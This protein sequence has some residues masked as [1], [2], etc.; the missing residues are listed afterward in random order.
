MPSEQQQHPALSSAIS[1]LDKLKPDHYEIYFERRTST[2]IDSKNLEIDSL[3][4]SEDVGLAIRLIKNQRMGFSFTTSLEDVAIQKAVETAYEVAKHM[5]ADPFVSLH[6]FDKS[7]YPHVDQFDQQGLD[8]PL[9]QKIEMAKS[10]ESHCRKADKRITG[11]RQASLSENCYEVQMVDSNGEPILYKSTAFV[12]SVSCKA[13]A[14][15]DSQMGGDFAF[16]HE[17]DALPLETVG[18]LA[19]QWATELLGSKSAPTLKCPALLRNAVVAELIE[20]LSSSFSAEQL[21]KGRSM[22]AGK[23]GEP[24]FSEHI[25]LIDDGLMNGGM[26]TAPFDGEG[27]PSRKNL[28]VNRGFISG[29]LYNLYYSNKAGVEPTS[30]SSRGIKSPPSIEFSNLYLQ[31]GKKSFDTL[32]KEIQK[33]ILITDLMGVHTANPVTG[34]FS[35]GASGILIEK[36]QLTTPVRGFAV[37]GNVLDL[38]RKV[39][40]VSNDLRFFGKVGAPSVQLS[41]LSI[42]GT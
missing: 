41:D 11:V 31:K 7:V 39:I 5:P 25:T 23:V 29:L 9:T 14:D 33:G 17:L 15:G 16:S 10:L 18:K 4:R 19:A 6:S 42:G 32:V 35:L 37:A 13:E 3:S 22:L 20:F 27:I 36:G 28:L 40:D 2:K 1:R 26:G 24:V 8:V 34:D 30:S 21:D 38:F 12:A